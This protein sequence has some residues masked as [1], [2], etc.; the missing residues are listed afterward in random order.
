MPKIS[1][2]FTYAEVVH[3]NVAAKLRMDNSLP[4]EYLP[5]VIRLAKEV[6]EEVRAYFKEPVIITS[7]WRCPA[8][9]Q[10]ISNNPNSQHT[11]GEAADFIVKNVRNIEV[12]EFIRDK[13]EFDQLILERS[14]IHCSYSDINRKEVLSSHDG[15]IFK[16]GLK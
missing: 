11:K 1:E 16:K 2:H 14:W 7:W 8:L 3:S 13:L 6:L 4:N 10:M 5:N 9:N 12:A 15:R